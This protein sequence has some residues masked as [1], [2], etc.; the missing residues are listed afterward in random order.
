MNKPKWLKNFIVWMFWSKDVQHGLVKVRYIGY[1][2]EYDEWRLMNEIVELTS[3][4]SSSD[5]GPHADD[6]TREFFNTRLY[7]TEF[8][9]S[10]NWL[11]G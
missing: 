5:E 9:C 3:D 6:S 4:E 1:G 10:R 7:L 8:V 11:I 2:P